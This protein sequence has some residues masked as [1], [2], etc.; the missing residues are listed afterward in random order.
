MNGNLI[1]KYRIRAGLTQDELAQKLGYSGRA[2]ISKI[3]SDTFE[4]SQD[5]IILCSEVLG[6]SP[7]VL[8]GLQTEEDYLRSEKVKAIAKKLDRL[9]SDG[10]D[11]VEKLIELILRY[12]SEK[13]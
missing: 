6:V 10:L 8:M 11:Q 1:R 2:T 13:R 3:E 12:T 4:L 5:K 7:L 9:P